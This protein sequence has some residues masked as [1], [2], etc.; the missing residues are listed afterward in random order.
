MMCPY[1]V[2]CSGRRNAARVA[3]AFGDC[4]QVVAVELGN[5]SGK[6]V[7]CAHGLAQPLVISLYLHA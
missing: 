4:T 5:N 1:T 2:L 7:Y 3:L 6:H